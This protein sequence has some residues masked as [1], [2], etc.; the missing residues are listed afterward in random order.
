MAANETTPTAET[1]PGAATALSVI[2]A[3]AATTLIG[4]LAPLPESVAYTGTQVLELPIPEDLFHDLPE[5]QRESL[6][7]EDELA[8]A[9]VTAEIEAGFVGS[10]IFPGCRD[11]ANDTTAYAALKSDLLGIVGDI[12]DMERKGMRLNIYRTP[13]GELAWN[14]LPEPTDYRPRLLL[15]QTYQ[16][17]THLG[18]YG[19]GR[20]LATFTL[21]PGEETEIAISSYRSSETHSKRASSVFDSF[22]THSASELQSQIQ[23]EQASTVSAATNFEYNVSGQMQACWGWGS[24][25]ISAG[26]GGGVSTAS[27]SF[28]RSVCNAVDRHAS[29]TSSHRDVQINTSG[30]TTVEQGETSATTRRLRNPNADHTLN[31]VFRQ[32]NQEVITL[33]SLVDAHVSY[34]DGYGEHRRDVTLPELEDLLHSVIEGVEED[35]P[36]CAGIRVLDTK[37]VDFVTSKVLEPLR[38]VLDYRDEMQSLIE[39]LSYEKEPGVYEEYVRVRKDLRSHYGDTGISVP[40]IIVRATRNVLRTDSVVVDSLLGTA[41]AYGDLA[42]RNADADVERL[43]VTNSLLELQARRERLA[44]RIVKKGENEAA[45]VFAT[46]FG[47]RADSLPLP[48]VNDEH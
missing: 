38:H 25:G 41:S 28:A 21:L 15:I 33:L 26:V 47:E 29:V 10:R 37:T 20:T 5:Y 8:V 39:D 11:A 40:G 19:P 18:R 30:E 16:L 42:Q 3:E 43:E 22:D 17:T 12:V 13:G 32:L 23:T 44:Q 2:D 31:F 27:E 45:A 14:Y 48:E 46:V 35:G 1:Q 34:F 24:A 7:P 36:P 6:P 4:H 9:A